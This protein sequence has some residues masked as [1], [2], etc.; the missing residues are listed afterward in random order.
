[1][2]PCKANTVTHPVVEVTPDATHRAK[3]LNKAS[4]RRRDDICVLRKRNCGCY[5]RNKSHYCCYLK[6]LWGRELVDSNL[7][8]FSLEGLIRKV[9]GGENF[10]QLRCVSC[11]CQMM[12]LK[13][14]PT[15]HTRLPGTLHQLTS[16]GGGGGG[17]GGIIRSV[18]GAVQKSVSQG[19]K[20]RKLKKKKGST[21][22]IRTKMF[23]VFKHQLCL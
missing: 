3:N 23:P 9:S 17:R 19:Y 12:Q 22:T 1:M 7:H 14:R 16:G 13:V 10:K 18:A 8:V 2:S 6:G 15:S 4:Q 21:V 20:W 11:G 5:C